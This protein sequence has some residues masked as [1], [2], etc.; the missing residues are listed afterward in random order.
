VLRGHGA[1]ADATSVD[2]SLPA[3]LRAEATETRRQVA[4]DPGLPGRLTGAQ[5]GGALV[6]AAE[7]GRTDALRLLLD[8]GFPAG[9]RAGERGSTALHADA[10]SGGAD[11][12]RLL[13][14]RGADLEARDGTWDS[15]PLEWAAIGSGERPASNPRPDWLAT[16][17]ALIEAGA[18]TDAIT[19]SADDPRPPSPEVAEF[20]R[21]RDG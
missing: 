12:V 18:S 10:Y 3:C 1:R 20:L 5:Q 6:Q 17:R 19:L 2:R 11:T 4:A 8:L 7:A 9:A 16:V 14:G 15:T 13:I 21:S